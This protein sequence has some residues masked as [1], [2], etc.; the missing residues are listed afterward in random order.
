MSLLRQQMSPTRPAPSV[1]Q[2]QQHQVTP[3]VAVS[4]K[5]EPDVED[6][7]LP[8]DDDLLPTDLSM[9]HPT[10]LSPSRFSAPDHHRAIHCH[11]EANISVSRD[12]NTQYNGVKIKSDSESTDESK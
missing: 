1:Q 12:S 11:Q 8:I 2:Q 9:E 7:D 4:I 10:D 5:V 3:P 6:G